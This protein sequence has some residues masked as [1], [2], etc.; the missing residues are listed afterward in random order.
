MRC[1]HFLHGVALGTV[2]LAA[3]LA[4]AQTPR[5]HVGRARRTYV[6]SARQAWQGNERIRVRQYGYRSTRAR[7]ATLELCEAE[8]AG[9]AAVARVLGV[10]VPDEWPP[11]VFEA[12]DVER[13]RRQLTGEL[14]IDGWILHYVLRRAPTHA[15]GSVLI[16]VAG[17]IGHPTSEGVVEI[18]YAILAEH[19]RHGYATEA[20]TALIDRALANPSVRVV[21]ATTYDTLQPSIR[22]L[23]KTGFTETARDHASGLIRF[24]RSRPNAV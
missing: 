13:V 3:A 21:V 6:D 17:Y 11:A 14:P 19:Q 23:Q 5:S 8:V 4:T 1:S 22:V 7:A 15:A 10:S 16:G 18:G 24:E 12:D 9:P 20:V 2:S